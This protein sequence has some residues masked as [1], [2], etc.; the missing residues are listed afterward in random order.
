[1]PSCHVRYH[2]HSFQGL[3]YGHFGRGEHYSFCHTDS[4]V[5]PRILW[6]GYVFWILIC[7]LAN[8][9][10]FTS[11]GLKMDRQISLQEASLWIL[12]KPIQ[13]IYRL[14][15]KYTKYTK[16]GYAVPRYVQVTWRGKADFSNAAQLWELASVRGSVNSCKCQGSAR[17][18][19]KFL[20]N[21]DSHLQCPESAN[22]ADI[23]TQ[24][25]IHYSRS[26]D[27]FGWK[28]HPVFIL[29]CI[30]WY[31]FLFLWLCQDVLYHN[32]NWLF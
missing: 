26:G 30:D 8:S 9:I 1:M 28:L 32:E 22:C 2:S 18:S 13:N 12:S 24:K 17:L 15:V 20:P 27:K 3:G 25:L 21:F 6:V 16:R 19:I 23:S 11:L 31:N 29:I 14:S 5:W 7:S 4:A 10:G